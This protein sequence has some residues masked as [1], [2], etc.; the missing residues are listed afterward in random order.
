MSTG[1]ARPGLFIVHRTRPGRREDVRRVWETHMLPAIADNPGHVC[2]VYTFDAVE[3]DVI[4][5]FQEYASS[6][7]SAAFLAGP[8]YAAYLVAVEPLLV[9]EPELHPVD[10]QWRKA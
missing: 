8:A 1:G 3:P 4:R 9:D 10:V 2:Y 7:S 5:V 6:E